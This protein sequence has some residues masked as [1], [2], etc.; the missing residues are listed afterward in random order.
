MAGVRMPG[1][2]SGLNTEAWLQK[3]MEAER[4]GL[5]VLDE[6]RTRHLTRKSAWDKVKAAMAE[7]SARADA[8]RKHSTFTPRTA[9]SSDEAVLK[10]TAAAGAAL[11]SHTVQVSQ[12]AQANAIASGSFTSPTV[13]LGVSGTVIIN[14]ISVSVSSSDTLYSLRDRLN[15]QVSSISAQ[16]VQVSAGGSALY[17]LVITSK[18]S[19]LSG[20]ITLG[21][22]ASS[23]TVSLS[24]GDAAVATATVADSTRVAAGVHQ[25]QVKQLATSHKVASNFVNPATTYSGSFTVNGVTVTVNPSTDL[26]GLRDKINSANAGVT[27]TLED[28]PGGTGN[29]RLVLTADTTGAGSAIR[30]TDADGILQSIGLIGTDN[31]YLHQVTAAQDAV[32]VVD[33]QTFT[34]GRNTTLND[35]VAGLT[36]NLAG[37]GSTTITASNSGGGV[38]RALG[39]WNNSGDTAYE[40]AAAQDA[41]FTVDGAGFVR[42]TNSVS[43]ALAGVTLDL[44]KAGTSTVTVSRN[45]DAVVTAV[46][47]FVKAYNGAVATLTAQSKYDAETR[48]AAP[49]AGDALIRQL[50]RDLRRITEPVTG[51]PGSLNMLSQ[52]GV[53]MGAWGSAAWGQLSVDAAKLKEKLA[54]D[55]DG[56]ARLFGALRVNTAAATAGSTASASSTAA[57]SYSAADVIN[58][59]TG[60]TRWGS[61]GGGWASANVPSASSPEYLTIT[62]D[63]SKTIDQVRV[64]SLGDS[65]TYPPDQ[66]ALRDYT[67]EYLDAS[68]NWQK[69]NEVTANTSA[70]NILDFT[71]VTT[72]SIRLKITGTNGG[73]PAQVLEVEAFL[74]DDGAASRMYATASAASNATGTV[75]SRQSSLDRTVKDLDRRISALEARL[76]R[77]EEALRRRFGQMEAALAR[78]RSQ[79]Q[80]VLNQ[81]AMLG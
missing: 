53:T 50:Q 16:V 60:T 18:T 64:T 45:D 5:N 24:G 44:K 61:S 8:L 66:N 76:A 14:N 79:G 67:L 26:A 78:L 12:L 2:V 10:A 35:V 36:L 34:R 55:Q 21:E 80:G 71:A 68:G 48:T 65:T 81:M 13:A 1:L 75:E 11:G 3:I 37:T 30:V 41:I 19:G 77:R 49:L 27:A 42:T 7:L 38:L 9:A 52:A 73:K 22:T 33:G 57:G 23:G 70:I 40:V 4:V 62:F 15:S 17:Q 43:D 63:G 39:L 28:E 59:D 72:T 47:E 51:L 6:Q 58:G 31:A 56:V 74:K 20:R 54:A 46:Q 69:L 29:K 25:I 32:V